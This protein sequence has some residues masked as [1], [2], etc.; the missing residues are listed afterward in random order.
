HVKLLRLP[1]LQALLKL[2]GKA[3]RIGSGTKRLTGQDARGLMVAVAV[4]RAALKARANHIRAE[5]ANHA[6]HVAQRDIVTAPLLEGLFRR[7]G[8]TKV[9]DAGEALLDSIVAIC[10]QQF[11]R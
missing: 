3:R 9:G 5:S 6:H 4:A 8:E 7:L 1:R 2:L 11:E 10:G